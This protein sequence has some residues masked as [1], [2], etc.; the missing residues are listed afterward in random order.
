MTH[1]MSVVYDVLGLDPDDLEWT[2]F[3]VCAG[4]RVSL[5]YDEY[6]S[7]IRTAKNVD[8]MCLSCPVRAQC[9]QVGVE[10]NEWGCWGGVFLVSGKPDDN[11]NAHKTPDIWEK[12]REGIK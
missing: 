1:E 6:E 11:K 10:N 2:D 7:N 3:A 9:L 12:I 8:Q 4:Q 5:F